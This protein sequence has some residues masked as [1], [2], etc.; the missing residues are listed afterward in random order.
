[1]PVTSDAAVPDVSPEAPPLGWRL[2][3]AALGRVPQGALSR[4][5]GRI[6]DVKLPKP[7]RRPVLASF[8]R[9]VGVDVSEA[10]L[11]LTAYHS[12]NHFFTRRL[13]PG[14]RSW[15]GTD[16]VAGCP[17]DG[18]AGQAGIV[19]AG[20]IVQAK[21]RWYSAAELV[22]DPELAAGFEG[23]A[24]ATL[25]LSPRH[26]H[27][28]HAPSS[29]RIPRACYLPGALLPVNS[30]AVAHV[31]DLFARNERLVCYLDGPLGRIAVVAIGAYNVGRISAAFEPDWQGDATGG[32]ATNRPG[33]RVE[34]RSYANAPQ[35]AQG[36]EIMAFH[37]GS[38]VVVLFEPGAVTLRPNLRPGDE[39]RLGEPLAFAATTA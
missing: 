22:G 6:A 5:L 13:R 18:I 23:G 11:P 1:M 25:Y 39:V 10:E 24:F 36:D 30:P 20:R 7:I 2:V 34:V 4:G 38:T 28:I 8:A 29:G 37:L 16:D 15:P 21:G 35:V 31:P 26:Y 33:A 27:R 12:V 9:A 32:W 17:V 19:R 3:L 14:A